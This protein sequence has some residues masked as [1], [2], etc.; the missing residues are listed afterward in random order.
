[1]AASALSAPTFASLWQERKNLTG[2][3]PVASG[4]GGLFGQL[5]GCSQTRQFLT[6]PAQ[7][8]DFAAQAQQL[9]ELGFGQ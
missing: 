3:V 5:L 7:G 4:S 2:R 8:A 9:R 6:V 1:M